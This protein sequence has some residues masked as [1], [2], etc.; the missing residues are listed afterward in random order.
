MSV[1]KD[2]VKTGIAV[3]A[4]VLAKEALPG[5]AATAR[6]VALALQWAHGAVDAHDSTEAAEEAM[7]VALE[8]Y[9]QERARA[10]FG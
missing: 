1:E 6:L 9:A 5:G 2:L 4:D 7:L 8:G 10:R 3:A